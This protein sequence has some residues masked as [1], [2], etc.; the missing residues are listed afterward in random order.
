MPL[1]PDSSINILRAL[2]EAYEISCEMNEPD[3]EMSLLAWTSEVGHHSFRRG[4]D[5]MARDTM[6]KSGA[7]KG[8]IDVTFGW[9]QKERRRINN[10]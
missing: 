1:V 9:K 6:K 4:A 2:K 7:D 5:K 3:L 10:C 8:D